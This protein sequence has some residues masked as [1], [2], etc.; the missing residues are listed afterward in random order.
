[1][2]VTRLLVTF[3]RWAHA[4]ARSWLRDVHKQIPVTAQQSSIH[5]LYVSV[6]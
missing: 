1:M 2:D 5:R 3:S 6:I 4:R